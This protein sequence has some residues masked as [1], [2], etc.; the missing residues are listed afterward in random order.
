MSSLK[1]I[2]ANR[3]NAARSTG[4][5]TPAGRTASSGNSLR[6]GL[7]AKSQVIKGEDPAV[8]DAL[9]A[10]YY[11]RFQPGAPD[12][13]ALLDTLISSEWLL[14]RLRRVE[15]E[16]WAHI[17]DANTQYSRRSSHA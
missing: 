5:N 1:Q 14:R 2:E 7:Y 11:E 15:A 3:R 8:F 6:T 9:T 4:P 10:D 13:R 12:Q 16:M 17:L